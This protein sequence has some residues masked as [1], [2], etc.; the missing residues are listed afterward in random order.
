MIQNII[1][2]VS[3]PIEIPGRGC[4]RP[5][6]R[7]TSVIK[8]KAFCRSP[9][10]FFKNP[11][12]FCNNPR[13]I[14]GKTEVSCRCQGIPA[15]PAI[16]SLSC[17]ALPRHSDLLITFPFPFQFRIGLCCRF[18]SIQACHAACRHTIQIPPCSICAGMACFCITTHLSCYAAI[19]PSRL[20]G[21]FQTP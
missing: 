19:I 17:L 12:N 7:K 5:F 2:A 4:L 9:G 8:C 15:G 10:N 11:G 21:R 6:P 16:Y 1:E 18:A 20:S 14:W 3:C 13:S